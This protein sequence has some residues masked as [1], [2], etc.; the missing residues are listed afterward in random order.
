[1]KRISKYTNVVV[2]I[3]AF[4]IVVIL[5]LSY[6]N[7]ILNNKN[8][9]LTDV[10]SQKKLDLKNATTTLASLK[11][12]LKVIVKEKNKLNKDLNGEIYKVSSLQKQVKNITGAVGTLQK[13]SNTDKELLEKYSKVYF[14]SENYIPSK[15]TQIDTKY[16]FNKNKSNDK[17]I[18]AR[19]YPYLQMMLASSNVDGVNLLIASA[20]RSFTKQTRLKNQYSI[21]YGSGANKFSA[22]QGYSEHQLGTTIDFTTLKTG[23]NFSEFKNTNA[24]KW[25]VNNAYKFGFILSYPDKNK[26][27]ISESWHWRFIGVKLARI[28]QSKG[29]YFYDLSQREIDKYLINIF[30]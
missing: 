24:Y 15:L 18:H 9:L 10:L 7:Y 22:D 23:D 12:N 13:L 14:L 16:L 30:D 17:W 4:A 11:N 6:Q 26:Y 8:K 2:I 28:L 19:V 21:I 29:I 20:Y 25:L 27:Y 5:Y 3:F 1:M